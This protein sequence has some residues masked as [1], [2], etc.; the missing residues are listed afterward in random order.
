MRHFWKCRTLKSNF[1]RTKCD[2]IRRDSK[3]FCTI[4]EHAVKRVAFPYIFKVH[5]LWTCTIKLTLL[6]YM[7]WQKIAN[8]K[9]RYLKF[10]IDFEVILEFSLFFLNN[11]LASV[12]AVIPN[13]KLFWFISENKNWCLFVHKIEKTTSNQVVWLV[14][15]PHIKIHPSYEHNT[16][17]LLLLLVCINSKANLAHMYMLIIHCI[18]MNKPWN[19]CQ[20]FIANCLASIASAKK[21]NY[22]LCVGAQIKMNRMNIG[23]FWNIF[24]YWNWLSHFSRNQSKINVYLLNWC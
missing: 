24:A 18:A 11:R 10:A 12:L 7:I 6:W 17:G 9:S 3:S 19:T 16:I 14:F 15:T 13:R 21:S 22:E 2:M 1:T 5:V 4:N 23:Y 8:W 20:K